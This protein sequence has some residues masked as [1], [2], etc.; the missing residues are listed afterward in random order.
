MPL[1]FETRVLM[2]AYLIPDNYELWQD[3]M[4]SFKHLPLRPTLNEIDMVKAQVLARYRLALGIFE[5]LYFSAPSCVLLELPSDGFE[6]FLLLADWYYRMQNRLRRVKVCLMECA[7][8]GRNLEQPAWVLAS[9]ESE[10][11]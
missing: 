3:V 5:A 4:W 1:P 11:D 9:T 7:N 10:V 2:A 6:R 8:L